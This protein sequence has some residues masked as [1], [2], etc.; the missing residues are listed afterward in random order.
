MA[1]GWGII[2]TGWIML[3]DFRDPASDWA[4]PINPPLISPAV[5]KLG[6][7]LLFLMTEQGIEPKYRNLIKKEKKFSKRLATDVVIVFLA[8]RLFCAES[9]QVLAKKMRDKAV[10]AF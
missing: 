9:I 6:Y 10:L 7:N 2:T 3:R 4:S 5:E 1:E 8:H